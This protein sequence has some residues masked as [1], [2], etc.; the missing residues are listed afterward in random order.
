MRGVKAGLLAFGMRSP[1]APTWKPVLAVV[2]SAV[3][4]NVGIRLPW[5][6]CLAFDAGPVALRQLRH[7]ID[8]VIAQSRT[9]GQD[10]TRP[11][12][13][14]DEHVLGPRRAVNEVPGLEPSL[15]AFDQQQALA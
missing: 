9:D 8:H 11:V 3:G 1:A 6:A 15:L 13:G 2:D 5:V 10:R 14:A 12:A 7:W 4:R